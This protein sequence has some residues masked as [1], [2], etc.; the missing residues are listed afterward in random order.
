MNT[1]PE[2]MASLRASIKAELEAKLYA[3]EHAAMMK[4]LR[5]EVEA[6]LT[7]PEAVEA[8]RA[9]IEA[10]ILQQSNPAAELLRTLRPAIEPRGPLYGGGLVK[11]T[12][13]NAFSRP[14][15]RLLADLKCDESSKRFKLA[16]EL[17]IALNVRYQDG[18][19]NERVFF[20]LQF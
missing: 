13:L 18:A 12:Y 14:W 6:E 16:T 19:N 10:E 7:T 20:L 15:R 5:A 3:E 1:T 8:R 2:A 11:S 4:A 9:S 17:L